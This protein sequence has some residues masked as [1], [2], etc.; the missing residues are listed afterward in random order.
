M[1]NIFPRL[2]FYK[3][4]RTYKLIYIRFIISTTKWEVYNPSI[5][6][7]WKSSPNWKTRKFDKYA[8]EKF[9]PRSVYAPWFWNMIKIV[10]KWKICI[11]LLGNQF[12]FCV[13]GALE[14]IFRSY[15]CHP[16]H[17]KDYFWKPQ[18]VTDWEL[19]NFCYIPITSPSLPDAW[20][21]RLA[22]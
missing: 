20:S 7:I 10:D 13:I 15:H 21:F 9:V 3:N 11:Q 6:A 2:E 1:C 8:L 22:G 19:N 18:S 4:N 16:W 17:K 5:L 12:G 14:V